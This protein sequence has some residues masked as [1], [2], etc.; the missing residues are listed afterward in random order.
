MDAYFCR[1]LA[2]SY[3]KDIFWEVLL[4]YVDVETARL[5]LS[6]KDKRSV[7]DALERGD[8]VKDPES[9]TVQ[10]DIESIYRLREKKKGRDCK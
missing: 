9:K 3:E 4:M 6:Y 1:L 2:L 8:L 7:Y 5:L 10:I